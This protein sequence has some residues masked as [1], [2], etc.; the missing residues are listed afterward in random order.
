VIIAERKPIEAITEMVKGC[1]K[2]LVSGCGGCVTVCLAGGEKEAGVLASQ[3]RLAR[4]ELEVVEATV[5]RHCEYEFVDKLKEP[6]E[7]AD[8][9][10]S[11]AC[12]A[13]V[14]T[15]AEKF[16][17]TVVLP[18]VDT[19]FIGLATE[20][21]VWSERC[22]ACG[23]CVLDKTGGICPIARCS[24]SLLNGPCGGSQYGKCEVSKD[25]DCGW[26]LIYDRL[27]RLNQLD[28]LKEILG[29]KNWGVS[30]DGGPRKLVRED[31]RLESGK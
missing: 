26:Q 3:L 28:K 20:Q 12:G 17:E 24:K 16:P 21:G 15:V 19:R 30:R 25:V 29:P 10:I 1:K 4:P 11:M 8:A 13:G 5:D 18:G 7:G 22:L 9:I 2:V 14:Q 31:M 23:D 6:A 27:A